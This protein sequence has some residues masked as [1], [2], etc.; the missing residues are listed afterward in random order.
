M[1]TYLI[2]GSTGT[3][4]QGV[5]E[6]LVEQGHTV[7][8]AT[9]A[10]DQYSGVGIPTRLDVFDESTFSDAVDGVDAMFVMS[11]AGHAD[12][13]AALGPLVRAAGSRVPRIVTMTAQGVQH[14]DAIPLR[15][16]ELTVEAT[17]ASFVH[18]RPSWFAQNFNS[19]WL[20]PILEAGVIPLPAA[21]AATGFIDA[22]DISATVAA[23][24]QNDA[25]DGRGWELTG[26][27]AMTYAQAAAILSEV[28]GRSI[29]YSAIDDDT[30]LKNLSGTP[31]PVEYQHLLVALFQAVRAGSAR[32]VTQSVATL[33]GT[34]PRSLVDY[35]RDHKEVWA[36]P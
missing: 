33:T 36:A 1:G 27:E 9:R 24:L 28:S 26:P 22:R 31:L 2:T 6:T 20:P 23:V 10:P 5:V 17:E 35:A 18:L 25:F 11:P 29:T 30:F 21:D 32:V 14:D 3:V 12:A 4:G 34:A 8:A 13:A 16:L 15:Q 19:F 7:R